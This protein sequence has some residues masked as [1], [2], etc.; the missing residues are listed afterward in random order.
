[1]MVEDIPQQR[2]LFEDILRNN[3]SVR[4]VKTRVRALQ[5]GAPDSDT[6]GK[7]LATDPEVLSVERELEEALGTKVK[8][9]RSGATGKIT[10]NFYSPEEFHGILL[11]LKPQQNQPNR[12]PEQPPSSQ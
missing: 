9:E 3:L 5:Q 2:S 7:E 6:Q 10:I 12:P 8:V 4:E 11:K 1:M